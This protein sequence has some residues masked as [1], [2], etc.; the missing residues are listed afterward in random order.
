V[1]GDVDEGIVFCWTGTGASITANKVA[2]VRAALC[3]DA[4]KARGARKWN[5]ANVLA[6][7]LRTT[8]E[9]I[10]KVNWTHGSRRHIRMMSGIISRSAGSMN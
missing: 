5:H 1:H 6:I 8:L 3:C 10:A 9:A 7:S 2:G 4:E